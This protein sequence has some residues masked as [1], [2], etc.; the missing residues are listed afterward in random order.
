MH[1]HLAPPDPCWVSL[2]S[3]IW[4]HCIGIRKG[5]YT[6]HLPQLQLIPHW[7]YQLLLAEDRLKFILPTGSSHLNSA[8]RDDAI[9]PSCNPPHCLWYPTSRTPDFQ[10]LMQLPPLSNFI[11]VMAN[12][13]KTFTLRGLI[14]ALLC[15]GDT[16]YFLPHSNSLI[17]RAL[18]TVE[19]LQ[20][21]RCLPESTA[22]VCRLLLNIISVVL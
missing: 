1:G 17:N 6:S 9:R 22:D 14:A 5:L 2:G 10:N 19:L 11:L 21:L 7:V 12:S 13:K 15:Q 4:N 3:G 8:F 18:T 16:L 20:F